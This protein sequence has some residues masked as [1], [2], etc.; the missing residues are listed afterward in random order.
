MKIAIKSEI[1]G[2]I[3]LELMIKVAKCITKLDNK[4]RK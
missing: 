3:D 2:K 4:L 1:F